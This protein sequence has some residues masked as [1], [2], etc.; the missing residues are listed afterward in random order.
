[1]NNNFF[2]DFDSLFGEFSNIFNFRPGKLNVK[3]EHG[4]DSGGKWT[5]QTCTSQDGTYQVVSIYRNSSAGAKSKNSDQVL[6]LKKQ[7]E[8]CV[9]SQ[10]FEK[11][12]ELRDKIKSIEQNREKIE[13]LKQELDKAVKAQNFEAAIELRDQ[14]Q[15][16]S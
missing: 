9:E 6:E 2:N 16:L 8:Q 15:S 4:E 10:E 12:A 1:M 11:A 13:Q 14:I 7:L 3:T 5:K